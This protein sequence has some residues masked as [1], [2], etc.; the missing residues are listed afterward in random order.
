MGFWFQKV[1]GLRVRK[2]LRNFFIT[3]SLRRRAI[4]C[5]MVIFTDF[6]TFNFF[7]EFTA[8]A[9]LYRTCAGNWAIPFKEC[10]IRWWLEGVGTSTCITFTWFGYT[11]TVCSK[12]AQKTLQ[13]IFR[14]LNHH[15]VGFRTYHVACETLPLKNYA[16]LTMLQQSTEKLV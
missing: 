10:F 8:R 15:N 5:C 4:V 2:I 12:H 11:C 6:T 7:A 16:D 13:V 3:N 9:G 14:F 1:S